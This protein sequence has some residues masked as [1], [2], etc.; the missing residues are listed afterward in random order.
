M[1]RLTPAEFQEKHA[2][3]LKGAVED[4]RKGIERVTEAPGVKAAAKQAKMKMAINE[5]IDTGKWAER[6]KKVTVGEWKDK[7]INKGLGRIASGIDGAS[8]KVT[9]FASQLLTVQDGIVNKVKAMPDMTLEDRI[10]RMTTFIRD[11]SKFRKK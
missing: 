7:A 1:S 3:R 4:I 10:N 11:M 5:A 6:T 9:D 2:R 8:G